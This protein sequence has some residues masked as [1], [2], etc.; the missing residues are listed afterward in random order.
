MVSINGKLDRNF[1][2][3]I[4]NYMS[5]NHSKMYF[6][7]SGSIKENFL[8][9]GLINDLN[10]CL[11]IPYP[12]K[13]LEK[14]GIAS[15]FVQEIKNDAELS[16]I[17]IGRSI[18]SGKPYY[19]K[20]YEKNGQSTFLLGET[21]SGKSTL[22]LSMLL[23]IINEDKPIILID[24]TGDT[25]KEFIKRIGKDLLKRVIYI[26]PVYTP[27]SMNILDIPDGKNRDL[28][29]TRIAEDTIQV[30]KNVTEAESGIPGGLVGSKIEEIMRQSI[31]GLINIKGSTLL[32]ISYIITKQSV[33]K[34]L[35][36]ISNDIEFR[37]F[38]EDLEHFS[39]DDVSSTRRI[40]S[41]LK[42]NP[43]LRTMMCNRKTKFRLSDAMEK[44]MIVI[45]N[46]ERGRVG[47]RVFTFI[48]SSIIS[49]I[50]ISLQ[51]RDEKNS[52][53]L[54]C[55][56]FQD[57]IN[58]SFEDMVIL[59]RKERLNLFMAT[60][61]LSTIPENVRDSIMA[62]VK[63]Y[64]LFHL[65]PSDA[66]DF[67]EKF[68][69][70]K[71]EFLNLVPG[72]AYFKNPYESDVCRI[73]PLLSDIKGNEDLFIEKSKSFVSFDNSVSPFLD[74]RDEAVSI[75][76]DSLLLD[77]MH[78]VKNISNIINLR[79]SIPQELKS[80]FDDDPAF[81]KEILEKLV[82]E[83]VIKFKNDEIEISDLW[84]LFTY[85]ENDRKTVEK[86]LSLGLMIRI[87][88]QK[89]LS[90]TCIPYYTNSFNPL[91]KNFFTVGIDT[92]SDI[93]IT[94]NEKINCDHCYSFENFMKIIP[95]DNLI[96]IVMGICLGSTDEDV[97]I[98]TT[99][100]IAD[101]L[102]KFDNKI[103]L[104]YGKDLERI[105]KKTLLDN[106]YAKDGKRIIIDGIRIKTLEINLKEA[107]NRFNEI[108]VDFELKVE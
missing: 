9:A 103:D 26:D 15:R 42:T 83:K 10:A 104:R 14:S 17:P 94:K 82:L 2:S 22:M 37:D 31:S 28:A 50:W 97:L 78:L 18:S 52:V 57:Y 93:I 87:N 64:I 7:R 47:E 24:P 49:M 38:L 30:L 8:R 84:N 59:G 29:I 67:S 56:E 66:R 27:V 55:D 101:A 46:G 99:H 106:N 73:V 76:L 91:H 21:G 20:I 53:F 77:K 16:S 36:N 80:M 40:L 51:E 72:I 44:N 105:V 43:V 95:K 45:V 98:T 79:K 35:K 70:G 6:K 4:S 11:F 23:N 89:P 13:I 34:H 39:I 25:A 60:T 33:R 63:N 68:S 61:H 12:G 74:L 41:F 90:L 65:S 108:K 88:S 100:R 58:S 86:L 107:R 92:E 81:I 5:N 32:D 96:D 48:L 69:I 102:R 62:N 71:N 85:D 3:I 19:L 1:V 54:F 75:F